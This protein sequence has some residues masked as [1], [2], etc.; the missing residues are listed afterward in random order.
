MLEK[1]PCDR[2]S[3]LECYEHP[4]LEEFRENDK[5]KGNTEMFIKRLRG[6]NSADISNIEMI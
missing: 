2:L 4:A 3:A 1:N 5:D 6:F